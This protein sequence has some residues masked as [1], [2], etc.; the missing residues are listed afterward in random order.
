MKNILVVFCIALFFLSNTVLGQDYKMMT[1]NIRYDNPNDGENQWSKRKEFLSNQLLFHEP[2]I[3]GIQEGLHHQVNYLDSILTKYSFIGI[4]RDD[5]K[6]KGEYSAIFYKTDKFQIL[7][8]STFWLSKTPDTISVGW[9]ASME[10]I[11]TYGLFENIET[12]QSFWVFNTHFDHIGIEA[13][14][15]S[16]KLIVKKI[17]EL[18]SNNYQVVLMGDLNLEPESK[19]IQYLSQ[20]MN[21][22]KNSSLLEP[23]GPNGTFNDFQFDKPVIK[24]IDYIFTSK[25]NIAV[26]K[27]AV[28]SDSKKLKYSSDHLPVYVELDFK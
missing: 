23:F 18:N 25:N 11:C 8:Q 4:G 13:R 1:Y 17:N 19:P 20:I 24:R 7:K 5:G 10:R 12:N 14:L 28:L 27:Y 26:K 16:S 6:E 15:E 2:D 3:L 22:S 21:D 9:D